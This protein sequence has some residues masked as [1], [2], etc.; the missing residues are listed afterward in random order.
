V[1]DALELNV[2]LPDGG[3]LEVGAVTLTEIRAGAAGGATD[4]DGA[5]WTPM[6]SGIVGGTAGGLLG[7]LG[8]LV[9]VLASRRKARRFVTG[10]LVGGFGLGAVAV[11]TGLVALGTGQPYHVWFPLLLLGSILASVFGANGRTV[12]ARYEAME[13]QK[14]RAYDV[15]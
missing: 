9:G 7:V 6:A 2:V 4:D 11:V 12:A 5:W 3:R 8:A 14:I 1:P 13:L 15:S 10:I